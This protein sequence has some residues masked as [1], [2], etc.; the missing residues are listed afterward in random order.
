MSGSDCVTLSKSL[1]PWI[2]G[3]SPGTVVPA[4]ELKGLDLGRAP[5]NP[6]HQDQLALASLSPARAVVGAAKPT[7]DV[8]LAAPTGCRKRA[9]C[10]DR[11]GPRG[12]AHPPWPPG[13]G[14]SGLSKQSSGRR[15]RDGRKRGPWEAPHPHLPSLQPQAPP[16]PEAPA[17]P[18]L[19][20]AR[21]L[22]G[23]SACLFQRH[24]CSCLSPHPHPAPRR[25]PCSDG[26][27]LPAPWWRG[28]GG[29]SLGLRACSLH[30]SWVLAG[31]RGLTQTRKACRSK[32]CGSVDVLATDGSGRR[33][34]AERHGPL[35][36]PWRNRATWQRWPRELSVR[37]NPQ[38]DERHS[39]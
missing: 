9:V 31:S 6:G 32:A 26:A 18:L 5:S 38:N 11:P 10:R 7:K 14:P 17:A 4:S 34:F 22:A 39:D 15:E 23:G 21:S 27:C 20:L 24:L 28:F 12:T 33:A 1:Q 8:F 2:P 37:Q 30:V 29:P 35:T 19:G 36:G 13:S 25:L 3:F 16:D